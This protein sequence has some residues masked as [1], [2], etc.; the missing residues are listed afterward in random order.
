MSFLSIIIFDY[1]EYGSPCIFTN[2]YLYEYDFLGYK[3]EGQFLR[4]LEN[5]YKSEAKLLLD[6][7]ASEVTTSEWPSNVKSKVPFNGFQIL[8]DLSNEAEAKLLVF[9]RIANA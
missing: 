5:D 7:E 9:E 3:T 4:Q 2:K 8:I 1:S 6:S